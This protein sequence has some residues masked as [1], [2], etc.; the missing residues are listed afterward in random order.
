MEQI[1][2]YLIGLSAAAF[3]SS[4]L[5]Q[6]GEKLGLSGKIIQILCGIFVAIAVIAPIGHINLPNAQNFAMQ[7][8]G[9]AAEYIAK[10][11]ELAYGQAAEY[12]TENI[13]AYILEKA[14]SINA[15]LE[16][17]IDLTDS[18]IP[19]PCGVHIRGSISPNGKKV[20]TSYIAEELGIPEEN[21]IWTLQ[22]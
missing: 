18:Q 6:I 1:G 2:K 20:L 14:Q 8:Q 17:S 7:L 3:L 16:V 9:D 10:G 4:I 5:R 22:S 19:Q 13:K 11:Q 21:Q 12:I 15:Q